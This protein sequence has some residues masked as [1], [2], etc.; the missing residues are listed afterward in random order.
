M[1]ILFVSASPIKKE[2]SIGNT[3]LNL[4]KDM[5]DV[6]LASICT[7]NGIP[8]PKIS[9]CFCITEKMIINNILKKTPV[10]AEVYKSEHVSKTAKKEEKVVNFA[11]KFRFTLFFWIQDL[12]WKIGRWKSPELE[13]FVKEYNP[14]IIFTLLS[15]SVFLNNLILHIVKLT[16]KKLVLYAWDNNYSLKRFMFSPLRWIKLFIDRISMK[17]LVNK[18]SIFYVISNIQREE[19]ERIFN[20]PCKV[21]TKFL[22]FTDAPPVKTE[23]NEPLQLVYTGNIGTNRW[24][25]LSLIAD[26]LK[27]INKD[28]IKAQLRI[29]TASQITQQMSKNLNVQDSSFIMGSLTSKEVAEVQKNADILVH[30]EGFDLKF[31]CALHQSFSTK[32]V[33]YFKEARTILAIAPYDV[34]SIDELKRHD[35]AIVITNKADILIKLKQ[36]LNDKALLDEYSRK[37]YYCGQKYHSKEI[38]E[39]ILMNDLNIFEI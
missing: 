20:K 38:M 18:A 37:A 26:A 5:K 27:E 4:F 21:L 17:K 23:Y 34:A 14:D 19:Y 6:E 11:K 29:Y 22:D 9:K 33:D 1:K 30:V 2:L 25:T 12:I 16:N 32:L 24:R 31:R 10:G 28:S 13:R 36:I 8:D 15:N 39:T 35:G 3:F 7:R